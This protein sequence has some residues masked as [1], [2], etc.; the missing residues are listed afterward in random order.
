MKEVEKLA[1]SL[2]T[3][4][5]LSDW[6]FRVNKRTTSAGRCLH[7]F[8]G[9]PGV[10]ELSERFMQAFPAE[11]QN[12]ILHEIA[13]ALTPGD[14]HGD[15]WKEACLRIG[16]RPEPYI[17]SLP[18]L[19]Q[20]SCCYTYNRQRPPSPLCDYLCVCGKLLTFRKTY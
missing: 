6:V 14:G 17:E 13:H 3:Q 8:Q 4:Y 9:L 12:T 2:M 10:I 5:G 15:R 11:T 19:Y 1:R 7:P 16:A 18:G 20:A